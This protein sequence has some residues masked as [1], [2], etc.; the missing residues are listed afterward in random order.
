MS[1]GV[2]CRRGSDLTLLWLW[3]RPAATA[4]IGPLGWELSYATG[5]ALK[6]KA[7]QTNKKPLLCLL[8]SQ[9]LLTQPLLISPVIQKPSLKLDPSTERLSDWPSLTQHQSPGGWG[10][11]EGQGEMGPGVMDHPG[12][13]GD[14]TPLTGLQR[15]PLGLIHPA[16]VPM[17]VRQC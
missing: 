5:A 8:H 3:C 11:R 16:A 1:C 9:D 17:W 4:P 12:W 15:P 10:W 7:K 14:F 6:S 2:G 13:R